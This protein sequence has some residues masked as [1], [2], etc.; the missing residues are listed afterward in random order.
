ML[1]LLI[2]GG[3]VWTLVKPAYKILACSRKL[4]TFSILLIQNASLM[5]SYPN[6]IAFAVTCLI[7]LNAKQVKMLISAKIV[8]KMSNKQ[9]IKFVLVFNLKNECIAIRDYLLSHSP[10]A[11]N[12]N[13][14]VSFFA[15]LN[16]RKKVKFQSIKQ[17][18]HYRK[19]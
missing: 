1:I 5:P 18:N 9:I 19:K 3:W 14:D 16:L 8:T 13:K 6:F 17:Q 2:Q 7:S 15:A 10:Q 4:R 12:N 11:Y